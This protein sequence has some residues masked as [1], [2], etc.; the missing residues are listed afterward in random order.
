[1]TDNRQTIDRIA[2]LITQVE[3]GNEDALKVFILLKELE[4]VVKDS[5]EQIKESA[6]KE[7]KNYGK[8]FEVFGAS[9]TV[10]EGA[11]RYSY[12]HIPIWSKL[13]EERKVIENAA[14]QRA[15]NPSLIMADAATGEEIL[16][17]QI[18]YDR[19]SISI[20]LKKY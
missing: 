13:E 16:P 19:E 2:D 9:V 12:K 20:T 10:K 8:T 17:A 5:L 15:L 3:D 4:G 11:G 18:T 14:K 7:A 6:I 1:M